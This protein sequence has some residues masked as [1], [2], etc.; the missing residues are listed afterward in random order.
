MSPVPSE[1]VLDPATLAEV[2]RLTLNAKVI[3]KSIIGGVHRSHRRG[4]SSVFADHKEYTAGDDLRHL[5]WRVYARTD[6]HHIRRYEEQASLKSWLLIDIS[7]SMDYPK[8]RPDRPTKLGL[9]KVCAATL[10]YLLLQQG[11]AVGLSTIEETLELR[12]ATRA[13][14]GQFREIVETLGQVQ[15][16]GRTELSLSLKRIARARHPRSIMV[17]FTDLLND[18][19]EGLAQLKALRGQG[20]ELLVVHVL[21]P[22]ERTFP[23]D[24]HLGFVCPE[25]GSRLKVDA[26]WVRAAYLDEFRLHVA[27]AKALCAAAQA[28]YVE[29]PT[30]VAPVDTIRRV[31][32]QQNLKGRAR[33]GV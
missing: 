32:R 2:R 7:A 20:H 16:H 29:A 22:D 31:L 17:L 12:L 14:R 11:D 15:A 10:A 21:D 9:A 6:R 25:T 24:G 1:S 8:E 33:L 3:A 30:D 13:R 26:A 19:L 18:G 5:D 27:K 4:A 23:F 28:L